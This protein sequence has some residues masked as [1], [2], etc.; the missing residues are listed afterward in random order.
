MKKTRKDF[1]AIAT[2][3]AEKMEAKFSSELVDI[4]ATVSAGAIITFRMPLFT[5]SIDFGSY[6][7]LCADVNKVSA[8]IDC[9]ANRIVTVHIY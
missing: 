8:S 9:H 5:N 2:K 6:A 7:S 1:K 3:I 4:F